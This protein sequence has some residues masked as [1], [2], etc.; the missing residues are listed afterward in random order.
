MVVVVVSSSCTEAP[1]QDP[2]APVAN[3]SARSRY[4]QGIGVLEI[5]GSVK[6]RIPAGKRTH[7]KASSGAK[8]PS[9]W[10]GG[11]GVAERQGRKKNLRAKRAPLSWRR[12]SMQGC[13]EIAVRSIPMAFPS[14]ISALSSGLSGGRAAPPAKSPN[15]IIER[16]S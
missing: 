4:Q 16:L 12:S 5:G 13:Y 1:A 14:P 15:G 6:S 8:R 11:T 9:V 3:A 2:V 7:R 10:V